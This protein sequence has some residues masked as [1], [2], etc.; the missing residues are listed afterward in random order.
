MVAR[1]HRR[2]PW[3]P[4]ATKWQIE[5]IFHLHELNASRDA[6]ILSSSNVA[7]SHNIWSMHI[8]FRRS[9]FISADKYSDWQVDGTPFDAEWYIASDEFEQMVKSNRKLFK[10]RSQTSSSEV[11]TVASIRKTKK[12]PEGE[13]RRPE[14]AVSNCSNPL[15]S[16]RCEFVKYFIISLFLFV[17]IASI[18]SA[19][20]IHF[21]CVSRLIFPRKK[22]KDWRRYFIRV[23]CVAT[24]WKGSK[25]HRGN[26]VCGNID[27][28]RQQTDTHTNEH[29]YEKCGITSEG[30]AYESQWDRR[31]TTPWVPGW[32]QNTAMAT[33]KL[34]LF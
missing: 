2:T 26:Y 19:I 22:S 5:M 9:I 7:P 32:T 17:S 21:T 27:G 1:I 15:K 12:K 16:S 29:A 31:R 20:G 3:I 33:A 30:K 8:L 34:L 28:D 4:N 24:P 13:K 6:I 23:I 18:L 11:S 25:S 14:R 10:W